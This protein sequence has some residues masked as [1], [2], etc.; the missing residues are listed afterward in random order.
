MV[1]IL[2]PAPASQMRI[3]RLGGSSF[4]LLLAFRPRRP[5][6]SPVPPRVRPAAAGVGEPPRLLPHFFKPFHSMNRIPIAPSPSSK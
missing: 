6:E 2:R 4:F 3:A 1:S 5:P